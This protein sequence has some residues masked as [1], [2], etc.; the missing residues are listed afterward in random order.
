[1][2]TIVPHLQ[3]RLHHS[4]LTPNPNLNPVLHLSELRAAKID[5]ERAIADCERRL[6]SAAAAEQRAQKEHEEVKRLLVA[7]RA[8]SEAAQRASGTVSLLCLFLS[9]F[10]SVSVT[11]PIRT[12][13]ERDEF[14]LLSIS[15]LPAHTKPHL[16]YLFFNRVCFSTTSSGTFFPHSLSC[17]PLTTPDEA[18]Q[19]ATQRHNQALHALRVDKQDLEDQVQRLAERAPTVA[20]PRVDAQTLAQV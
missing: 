19:L 7:E 5:A 6:K 2:K 8:A 11:F 10:L 3:T 1:M 17:T 13:C 18:A 9:L 4:L 15:F 20:A 12:Y 14:E 16:R